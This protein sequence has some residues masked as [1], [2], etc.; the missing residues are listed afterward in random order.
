M[1]RKVPYDAERRNAASDAIL[2]QPE[3]AGDER[4][5]M[6]IAMPTSTSSG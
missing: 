2:R 5:A 1:K 3:M 6:P 4:D